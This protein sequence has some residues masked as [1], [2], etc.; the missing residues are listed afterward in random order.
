MGRDLQDEPWR[1]KDRKEE[2]HA[3]QQGTQGRGKY[4]EEA[5]VGAK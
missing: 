3:R 5:G 1:R 2:D 4:P